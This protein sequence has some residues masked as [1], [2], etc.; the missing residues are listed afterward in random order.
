MLST[1]KQELIIFNNETK[2]HGKHKIR[3]KEKYLFFDT[4]VKKC[5]TLSA[6]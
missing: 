6:F 3:K 4:T 5:I 2:S 1:K